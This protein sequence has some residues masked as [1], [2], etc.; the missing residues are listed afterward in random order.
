MYVFAD[1]V[2]VFAYVYTFVYVFA[3]I[4]ARL[5]TVSCIT[6]SQNGEFFIFGFWRKL[7]RLDHACGKRSSPPPTTT[8]AVSEDD[9]DVS[10]RCCMALNIR[11]GSE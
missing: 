5:A 4:S 9:S 1:I 6:M 7:T 2:Y 10:V 3:D 8:E 11:L